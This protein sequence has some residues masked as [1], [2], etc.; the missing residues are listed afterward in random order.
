[1]PQW[2]T[3]PAVVR[4]TRSRPELPLIQTRNNNN[5]PESTLRG[6]F[7]HI[8]ARIVWLAQQQANKQASKQ[9][10][11]PNTRTPPLNSHHV[12]E[13]VIPPPPHPLKP[14]R[15]NEL[16]RSSISPGAKSKVKSSV[17][18]TIRSKV[19]ETYPLLEPYIEDI[20]PKK[21]QLDLV[22]L[23]VLPIYLHTQHRPIST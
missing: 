2:L 11:T 9:A 22:K 15:A 17:Q 6:T 4:A 20:L 16:T 13:R 18:R 10:T 19:L 23:Y 3:H 7:P 14:N 8:T 12:Q 21:E 1:M 5:N